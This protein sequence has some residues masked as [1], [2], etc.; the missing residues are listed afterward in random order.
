MISGSNLSYASI[1]THYE[2]D[3][4][5]EDEPIP[6]D[7]LEDLVVKMKC[8]IDD[9]VQ[10]E[11]TVLE[12]NR[13]LLKFK[14]GDKPIPPFEGLDPSR[15]FHPQQRSVSYNAIPQGPSKCDKILLSY[16]GFTDALTHVANTTTEFTKWRVLNHNTPSLARDIRVLD[17]KNGYGRL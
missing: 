3:E 13:A 8:E 6:E 12:F 10:K 1:G 11:K 5:S 14:N 17:K 9:F 15:V 16:L 2:K 4:D 7:E